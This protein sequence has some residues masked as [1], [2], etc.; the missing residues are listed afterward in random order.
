MQTLI[1]TSLEENFPKTKQAQTKGSTDSENRGSFPS[2][3]TGLWLVT[4]KSQQAKPRPCTWSFP[5]ASQF[6]PLKYSWHSGITRKGGKLLTKGGR[7]RGVKCSKNRQ[8]REGNFKTNQKIPNTIITTALRDTIPEC[9]TKRSIQ[10]TG[11]STYII[12]AVAKWKNMMAQNRKFI[13]QVNTKGN[14][15]KNKKMESKT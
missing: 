8:W 7:G 10:R 15:P 2:K 3:T 6:L 1:L 14:L 5:W 4:R 12:T 11:K 13:R 9:Y